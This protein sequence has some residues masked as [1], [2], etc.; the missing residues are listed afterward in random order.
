[1][2]SYGAF[3]TKGYPAF[4]CLFFAFAAFAAAEEDRPVAIFSYSDTSCGAW[5]KSATDE[6]A[7]AQ[8]SSWFRGFLSG[9]NKGNPSNQVQLGRMPDDDTLFLFVDKFCREN[10]L[11]PFISAAFKLVEELRERP[12]LA[13]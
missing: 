12:G 9:Y 8:Y 11:N 6:S 7:R 13:K 1:M 5:V 2:G 3:M 10:L 4:A